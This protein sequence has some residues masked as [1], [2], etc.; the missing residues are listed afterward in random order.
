LLFCYE[1]QR[2]FIFRALAGWDLGLRYRSKEV[3]EVYFWQLLLGVLEAA[4]RS[5]Y[6][7]NRN[8]NRDRECLKPPPERVRYPPSDPLKPTN[9]S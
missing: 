1:D 2:I 9:Q 7:N 3:M 6:S 5:L 4:D 8:A